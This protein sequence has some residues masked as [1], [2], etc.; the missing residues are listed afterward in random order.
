MCGDLSDQVAI[1]E[2]LIEFHQHRRWL[3]EEV[4]FAY[5]AAGAVAG[6]AA[7]T[8]VVQ[9]DTARTMPSKLRRM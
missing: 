4:A 5:R 2:V 7:A 8:V 1:N 3:F 6:S 9:P